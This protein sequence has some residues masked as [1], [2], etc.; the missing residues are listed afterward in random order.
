MSCH[1]SLGGL[2]SSEL[3]EVACIAEQHALAARFWMDLFDACQAEE[4]ER[5]KPDAERLGIELAIP[6]LSPEGLEIVR[7]ELRRLV[8][9]QPG[10]L[11]GERFLP[12]LAAMDKA[13]SERLSA[14][15][16]EAGASPSD[17]KAESRPLLQ[18]QTRV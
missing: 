9:E 1:V 12:F 17:L 10:L 18:E 3:G 6:A 11:S 16:A 15:L 7:G 8:S 14:A 13:I 2:K 4:I 5:L